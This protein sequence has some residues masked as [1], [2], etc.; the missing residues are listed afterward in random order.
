MMVLW[1]CVLAY[2][3][4]WDVTVWLVGFALY[5]AQRTSGRWL[6]LNHSCPLNK[7]QLT[8][9]LPDP[10]W[11]YPSQVAHS[12]SCFSLFHVH[13]SKDN[14]SI[15]SLV[16]WLHVSLSTLRHRPFDLCASSTNCRS[17]EGTESIAPPWY[18]CVRQECGSM[19][20]SPVMS[21]AEARE[22]DTILQGKGQLCAFKGIFM[23]GK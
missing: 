12:Y 8:I 21:P 2:S 7:P 13:C 22:S 16:P 1:A 10:C 18:P 4:N 19:S 5:S 14:Y 9:S 6:L 11:P 3:T 20:M 15:S 17:L 23:F